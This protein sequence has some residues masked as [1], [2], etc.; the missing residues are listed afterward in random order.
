[1]KSAVLIIAVAFEGVMPC[2]ADDLPPFA[3][4][5]AAV[6]RIAVAASSAQTKSMAMDA[7][8]KIAMGNPP[9]IEAGNEGALGLEEGTLR[10]QD[11]QFGR[12]TVRVCALRG[13]GRTA[14]DEAIDFLAKLS[15]DALGPDPS[16]RV[17]PAAQVALRDAQ[18]RRIPDPQRKIEFL[19]GILAGMPDGRGSVAAWAVNELCD[20]GSQTSLPVIQRALRSTWSGQYGLDEIEFCEARIRVVTSNPD[21]AR[22]IGSILTVANGTANARLVGWAV[23]E[24]NSMQTPAADAE[25]DRFARE[26]ERLPEASAENAG[27]RTYRQEILNFQAQRAK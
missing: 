16:Q 19:D 3:V 14:S 2:T 10:G 25:L 17:W 15:P 4:E 23:N 7:L 27:L 11:K 6:Q 12:P 20:R 5:C 24:L 21:R 8:E 1:M 22:A 13:I 9:S 26:I 18:I